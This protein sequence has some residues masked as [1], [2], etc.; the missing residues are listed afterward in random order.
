MH[1]AFVSALHVLQYLCACP[2][3][4][5]CWAHRAPCG[6]ASQGWPYQAGRPKWGSSGRSLGHSHQRMGPAGSHCS[7]ETVWVRHH[8]EHTD[9]CKNM[10]TQRYAHMLTHT[11]ICAHT[12]FEHVYTHT[13]MHTCLHTHT[14]THT[15]KDMH[16]CLQ[17]H[18][19]PFKAPSAPSLYKQNSKIGTVA[20]RRQLTMLN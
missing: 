5:P 6:W 9:N 14:L 11:Y 17:I 15:H 18:T 16:T 10:H 2:Q 12:K 7:Y 20:P 1:D 13:D 4:G 19:K 8:P 3:R